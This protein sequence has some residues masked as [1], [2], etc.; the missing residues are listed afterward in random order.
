[1]RLHFSGSW[2]KS[3]RIKKG[4]HTSS[5]HPSY[6][7]H[8][9]ANENTLLACFTLLSSGLFACFQLVFPP[10]TLDYHDFSLF[11]SFLPPLLLL[12]SVASNYGTCL[13]I[14]LSDERTEGYERRLRMEIRQGFFFQ[15]LLLLCSLSV[16]MRIG[17]ESTLASSAFELLRLAWSG[18]VLVFST[19]CLV[20]VFV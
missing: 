12:F 8:T 16:R 20:S 3:K 11:T 18:L 13:S 19:V 4:K 17:G 2:S 15:G 1:M 6:L 5:I 7:L 14:T 10:T 9:H